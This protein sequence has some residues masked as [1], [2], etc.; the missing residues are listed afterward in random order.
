[1]T[2]SKSFTKSRLISEIA[3]DNGLSKAIV[4]RMLDQLTAIAYC[5]A[6]NGFV[7]PGICKL[8][9]VA[10]KASRHRNP[11]TGKLLLIGER[12]AVK[13]VPLKRAK[14]AIAPN[15]D[16]TV[17]IIDD[18]TPLDLNVAK[19]EPAAPSPGA[20]PPAVS[21][22]SGDAPVSGARLPEGEDGQV[23]FPCP[24]CGSMIAAP[25][26]S[27]GKKGDCPFCKAALTVPQW[28]PE[29]K[30]DKQVLAG[31]PDAQVTDFMTFVCQACGQEI[32][33]PADMVGMSVEC[34]TCGTGLTVPI[35]NAPKPPPKKTSGT[36]NATK[37]DVSS[38]TIRIDL[39]DLQ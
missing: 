34:P 18:L 23:V 26:K 29:V 16:V 33:A 30:P 14:M 9:V 27:A 5:E 6:E 32:E 25:P 1:M 35:A 21:P 10:K 22:A 31:K 39:S 4:G 11:F 7:I 20:T 37:P 8:K 15:K 2:T 19:P 17:Q 36:P 24:E 28:K 38:M 12:K 3:K 13:I